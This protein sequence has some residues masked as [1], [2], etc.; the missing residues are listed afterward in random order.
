MSLKD[1]LP[2]LP[3]PNFWVIEA[4]GERIRVAA[5]LEVPGE[6][7]YEFYEYAEANPRAVRRSAKWLAKCVADD[8]E[9]QRARNPEPTQAE[10]LAEKYA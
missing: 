10:L 8:P 2:E 5:R 9:H 4:V 3:A 6:A 7:W 1:E